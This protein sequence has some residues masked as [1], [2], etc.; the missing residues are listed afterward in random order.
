[1]RRD[2]ATATANHLS[3]YASI[4]SNISKNSPFCQKTTALIFLEG[5]SFIKTPDGDEV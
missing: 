5:Y 1:V 2:Y 3:Q 4:R